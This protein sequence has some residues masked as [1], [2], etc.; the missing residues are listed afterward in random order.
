MDKKNFKFFGIFLV[1]AII[2]MSVYFVFAEV[3]DN[4]YDTPADLANTSD[5]TLTFFFTP[6]SN[7]TTT[8]INATLYSNFTGAWAANETNT[9]IIT[10]ATQAFIYV[11]GSVAEGYY[12]WNVE[13]CDDENCTFTEETVISIFDANK[14]GRAHV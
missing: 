6:T 1:L 4:T 11:N 12:L 9:T 10:N 3:I 13:V 5:S 2:L 8:P 14:I 7:Q